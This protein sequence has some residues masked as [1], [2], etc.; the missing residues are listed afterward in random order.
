MATCYI[1]ESEAE[2]KLFT[3]D[4]A[5][6]ER[7]TKES[8]KH[9]KFRPGFKFVDWPLHLGK[10]WTQSMEVEIDGKR[11]QL[12]TT[13]EVLAYESITVPAGTFMAYKIVLSMKGTK[14]YQ[15]W[16]A[17]EVRNVV[18]FEIFAVFGMTFKGE[19][20]IDY[21]KTNEPVIQPD[22]EG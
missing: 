3:E 15:Y 6:L 1:V 10:S 17:P 4:Y 22:K 8:K 7:V 5:I 21:Q 12:N 14:A 13:G 18:R 19:E 11:G 16:Y 9:V 2:T 20:M